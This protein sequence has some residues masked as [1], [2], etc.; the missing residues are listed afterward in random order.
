M[1][2]AAAQACRDRQNDHHQ[3]EGSTNAAIPRRAAVPRRRNPIKHGMP[4]FVPGKLC[5]SAKASGT[6]REQRRLLTT[7]AAARDARPPAISE[8]VSEG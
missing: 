1:W 6:T 3:I 7:T 2:R 8:A 5:A 4:A